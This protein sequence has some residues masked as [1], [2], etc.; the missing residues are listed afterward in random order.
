MRVIDSHTAGEPT[1]VIVDGGP[2][3][4]AGPL[5]ARAARLAAEHGD[6]CASVLCEPRGHDAMVGALL[7]APDD[8]DCAAGVIFFNT[9]QN[10]GMCGH[11]SIG[12]AVTLA[13]LGLIAPGSHR[14]D[15]PVGAVDIA[16]HDAHSA[17]VVNVESYRLRKAVSVDVDGVGRVTGDVAWGGNWFFLVKEVPLAITTGHI[18]PL[19]D[20]ALAISAALERDG[21]TGANGAWIEHVDLFG[22]PDDPD[23]HSRNFV[24]CPGGAY[25]RSPCGTGCSAKLA[26]LA[27][28]GEWPPGKDWIQESVIGSTYRLSYQPGAD[29]GIVPTITGQAFVTS[30]AH[31]I[32]DPADPYMR[33]IRL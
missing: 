20:L 33:G 27:S 32:F 19:T 25:D 31:L 8:P 28:D 15:T 12:V 24:L 11:T 23:A 18:R 1:R 9:L 4:G 5:A 22:P 7:V 2:D 30:E 16:L 3:L 17:S 10:L 6:F 26:C 21:I 14:L 13:H 29:G